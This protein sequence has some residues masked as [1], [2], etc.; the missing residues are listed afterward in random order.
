[1]TKYGSTLVLESRQ[2]LLKVL[3]VGVDNISKQIVDGNHNLPVDDS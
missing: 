3:P 1:M 2:N